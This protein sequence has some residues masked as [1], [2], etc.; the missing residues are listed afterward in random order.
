M[1]NCS[2]TLR[3]SPLLGGAGGAG[4]VACARREVS[5][6]EPLSSRLLASPIGPSAP[7]TRH[8]R[9]RSRRAGRAPRTH[10]IRPR[11]LAGLPWLDS[12][13]P[14]GRQALPVSFPRFA[15]GLAALR[16]V[17]LCFS[18]CPSTQIFCRRS[19]ELEFFGEATSRLKR[20]VQPECGTL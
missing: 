12:A 14:C 17:G 4:G 20:R 8:S 6:R 7:Q 2:G 13:A 18:G 1:R 10:A 19:T 3:A 16:Y 11:R 15:S 5:L 9:E